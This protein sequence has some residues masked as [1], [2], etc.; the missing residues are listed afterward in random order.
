M[1][2]GEESTDRLSNTHVSCSDLQRF[3]YAR[4]RVFVCMCACVCSHFRDTKIKSHSHITDSPPIWGQK[5][6]SRKV[7][8]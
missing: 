3:M 7:N 5:A 8:H 6:G 4:T 1:R 2:Y